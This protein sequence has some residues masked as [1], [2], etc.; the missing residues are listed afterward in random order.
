M[1][2]DQGFFLTIEGIEGA[3]KSS[4]AELLQKELES[5]GWSVVVTAEPGGDTVGQ[6]IRSL[7]LDPECC[8]SD[9]AELLLFEAARAQHVDT[10]I[11]PALKTGSVVICDRYT[12]SSLAYQGYARGID[13]STVVMLNNYAT[14]GLGPDLTILLDL[15]VTAGLARQRKVDRV[16]QERLEFHEAVR[17]GFLAIARSEPDRIV[18]ID[19]TQDLDQVYQQALEAVTGALNK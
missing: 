4:L 17:Q 8:I 19:A 15:P 10:T 2:Q 1:S 9:R 13:L 6:R 12:D 5:R 14:G 11:K 3:G 18:V 7:L 16:S